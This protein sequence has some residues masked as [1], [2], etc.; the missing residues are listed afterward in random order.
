[1][2]SLCN[3]SR[4]RVFLN[5][6]LRDYAMKKAFFGVLILLAT[7]GHAWAQ[8]DS[9]LKL[10]Y[11]DEY[12]DTLQ[13]ET[14]SNPDSVLVDSCIGSPTYLEYYAAKWWYFS[15]TYYVI[16]RQPAP[17][18]TTIEMSWTAIDTSYGALRSA[19]AALE[20]KYGT[21]HIKEVYPQIADSTVT[22]SKWYYLRFD[23]YVCVD[24]VDA[25][26][27][28]FP[29]LD[30]LSNGYPKA[31]FDGFPKWYLSSGVQNERVNSGAIVIAPNPPTTSLTIRRMDGQSIRHI[32]LFDMLGKRV[33]EG[34]Y[35]GSGEVTIDTRT[36][37][38][39]SYIVVC[40]DTFKSR[41]IV[42][43]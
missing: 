28:T 19:F 5:L 27:K 13:N 21:F 11:P 10:Q 37:M 30:S 39:G 16:H 4:I 31:Y 35:H 24:S 3:L 33:F 9:C 43:R 7:M 26:L 32:E 36:I 38:I 17:Y 41:V 20:T 1:M 29:D 23:N 15:F 18:D 14:Y 22:G 25:D 40:D 6:D 34:Q 42:T 2:E 8:G 12:H